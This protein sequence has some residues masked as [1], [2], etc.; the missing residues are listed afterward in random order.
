[1]AQIEK[2]VPGSFC[3]IE[4]GTS[5]QNTAK[6][7]YGALFGWAA[8]DFPMGPNDYYTMFL[9]EGCNAAAAYTLRPGQGSQGLA[10]PHWMIYVATESADESANRAAQAGG[11]VLAPAFDVYDVGRMAVLQDPTGAVFSV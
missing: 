1:M 6:S 11:Q 3:W 2:H 7:F 10:P 4:L 5:D 8:H 9:L